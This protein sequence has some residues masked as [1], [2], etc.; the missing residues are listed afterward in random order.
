MAGKR[1]KVGRLPFV[2]NSRTH[3]ILL[4]AASRSNAKKPM[5]FADVKSVLKP[6]PRTNRDHDALRH[7]VNNRLLARLGPDQWAITRTGMA[8]LGESVNRKTY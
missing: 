8:A 2:H 4:L 1:P 6:S 5:T 7:L 3:H